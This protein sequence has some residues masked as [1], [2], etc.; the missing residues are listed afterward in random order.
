M[1]QLTNSQLKIYQSLNHKKYRQEHGLFIADGPHLVEAA[2]KSCRQIEKVVIRP[3]KTYLIENLKIPPAIAASLPAVKFNKLSPSESPQGILAILK[4]DDLS[5]EHP[6]IIKNARRVIA[7]DR[8]TDPGNVGTIIRTA[9]AFRFNL[10]V[11]IGE[12]AEIYNPK[13][14][15]ATQGAIFNIPIME[16]KSA[17]RFVDIFA[18]SFNVIVFSAKAKKPLANAPRIKRPALVL[19]SEI[20]GVSPEIECRA[21]HVFRIEQSEAV[22]SLNVAVA[23]GIAMYRFYKG[24]I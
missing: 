8:I 22:E 5:E 4:S 18:G 20:A 2:L 15:R 24:A 9:A 19:G 7:L 3:D 23:A 21:G 17:Q 11:C 16:I 6:E 13:T 10:V 1:P 12:C 14:I